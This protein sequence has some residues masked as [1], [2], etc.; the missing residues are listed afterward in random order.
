MEGGDPALTA[1]AWAG[2]SPVPAVRDF[3]EQE[4]ALSRL[5]LEEVASAIT[6]VRRS[7]IFSHFASS[8]PNSARGTRQ[9]KRSS[10]AEGSIPATRA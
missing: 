6:F 4:I 5:S 7:P 2:S 8:R 3:G 9:P 1:H 10:G